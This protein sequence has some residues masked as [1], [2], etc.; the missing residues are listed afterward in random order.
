MAARRWRETWSEQAS[1]QVDEAVAN[2]SM[3]SPLAARRLLA[4]ALDAASSLQTMA[5]RGRIVPEVGSPA[6]REIFIQRYRLDL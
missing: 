6:I 3:D 2:I 1:H 5:E 4:D